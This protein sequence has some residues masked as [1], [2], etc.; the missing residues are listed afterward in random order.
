MEQQQI[1]LTKEDFKSK[2]SAFG[3]TVSV[4]NSFEMIYMFI[5]KIKK[6][7]ALYADN[8]AVMTSIKIYTEFIKNVTAE[9]EKQSQID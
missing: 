4:L 5:N 3:V 1:K 2:F 8:L 7:S 6:M 9:V